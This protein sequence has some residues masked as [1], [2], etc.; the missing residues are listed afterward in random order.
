MRSD[1]IDEMK[2]SEFI[3]T[4]LYVCTYIRVY[5]SSI[6]NPICVYIFTIHVCVF[7]IVIYRACA[8]SVCQSEIDVRT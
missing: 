3:Y 6:I 5:D 8:N 7:D 2:P 1:E 4:T